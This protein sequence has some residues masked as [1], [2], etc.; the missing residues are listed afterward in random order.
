MK[1]YGHHQTSAWVHS[2]LLANHHNESHLIPIHIIDK[3]IMQ[4]SS[5]NQTKI[6]YEEVK[7]MSSTKEYLRRFYKAHE[8]NSKRIALAEYY[9]YH[10]DYA[11][12]MDARIEISMMKYQEGRNKL[13]RKIIKKLM[14][15]PESITEDSH[16]QT[17]NSQ[18]T[19]CN[20]NNRD[21]TDFYLKDLNTDKSSVM[22]A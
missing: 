13:E 9:K 18:Q 15:E 7:L 22:L 16:S 6:N 11:Y 14:N 2:R 17:S 3:I 19:N 5:I 1:V 4:H 12:H 8:T 20:R 21:D 10:H